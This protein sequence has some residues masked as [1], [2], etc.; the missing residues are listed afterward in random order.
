M[1]TPRT[2]WELS[3]FGLIRR[4]LQS[5]RKY[6]GPSSNL[7]H[8]GDLTW[9]GRMYTRDTFKPEERIAL[10]ERADGELDGFAWYYPKSSEVA[11][12]IDPRLK[13]SLAWQEIAESMLIWS[14][15]RN[16]NEP[17][18]TAL[19][20]PE[21]ASDSEFAEFIIGRGFDSGDS[22]VMRFHYQELT[23]NVPPP[24]LPEG[25]VIRP[26]DP[27]SE[28]EIEQRVAIHRE[29]WHPSRF[30]VE[31]YR[32]LRASEGYDPEL[33]LVAV[34][35]D[36]TF[37]SYAICWPDDVNFCGEFEPVGTREAFRRKGLSRAVLYEGMRR[38][39]SRGY[40]GAYVNSFEDNPAS[41][42]LYLA[43][44]FSVVDRGIPYRQLP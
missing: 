22:P 40:T 27:E 44:G 6:S 17:V 26:I 30:T 35:P 15:E 41:C 5:G 34:A 20:I 9:Q 43:A 14:L 7:F 42:A 32:Q 19:T 1:T 29:V 23:G 12:Q 38:L 3:D 18:S 21:F 16:R 11:F 4:F 8:V 33:D 13:G 37:A 28:A 31:G 25:F 39:E 24:V 10:W 36:G 2:F